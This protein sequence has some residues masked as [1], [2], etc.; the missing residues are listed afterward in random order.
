[1]S[2]QGKLKIVPIVS[3]VFNPTQESKEAQG[4]A[5]KWVK[6]KKVKK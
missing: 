2:F 5:R 3:I 1:M 4:S 6:G